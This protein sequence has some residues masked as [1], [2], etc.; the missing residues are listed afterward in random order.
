MSNYTP[1]EG[2]T[3]V[4]DA[5][6]STGFSGE[7]LDWGDGQ[8]GQYRV[9]WYYDPNTGGYGGITN[10][11]WPED[12]QSTIYPLLDALRLGNG[13]IEAVNEALYI[14]SGNRLFNHWDDYVEYYNSGSVTCIRPA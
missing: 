13:T 12:F 8:T 11:N 2:R 7:S 9:Y 1:I 5:G 14:Y 3:L 10:I 4:L 6:T